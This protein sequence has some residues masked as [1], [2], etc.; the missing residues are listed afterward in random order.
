AAA[1]AHAIA[2]VPDG[3]IGVDAQEHVE[4]G[5]ANGEF[6]CIEAA[7]AEDPEPAL[8]DVAE[9]TG[10]MALE[11]V[12]SADAW[13]FA[14]PPQLFGH[15]F[16]PHP[17]L[18]QWTLHAWIWTS[19]PYDVVPDYQPQVRL[20]QV[21]EQQARQTPGGE[22]ETP[23]EDGQTGPDTLPDAVLPLEGHDVP[24]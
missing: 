19:D 1:S 3:G 10:V 22:G 5:S 24:R 9:L 23:G 6:S 20:C 2:P 8:H 13:D 21:S 12:V 17:D 14:D 16:H 18:P 11:Y 4:T 7:E 15:D